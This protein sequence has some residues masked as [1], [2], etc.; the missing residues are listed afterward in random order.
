MREVN[1]EA[2]RNDATTWA[3]NGQL[4][5]RGIQLLS[6]TVLSKLEQM[7][8][9]HMFIYRRL[10]NLE[11]R[12]ER[13]IPEEFFIFEDALGRH[14]TITL[15]W[16]D[17]WDAFDSSLEARFKGQKGYSRVACKRYALKDHR[18]HRDIH[19][20]TSWRSA[21]LPGSRISMSI[22]CSSQQVSGNGSNSSACCPC[23]SSVSVLAPSEGTKW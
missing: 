5:L 11:L 19:H 20:N 7:M 4:I 13:P 1:E 18:R 6:G 3:E 2:R 23:C 14:S 12:I 16:I 22:S 10:T 21:M 17:S 15:N 9:L 8:N